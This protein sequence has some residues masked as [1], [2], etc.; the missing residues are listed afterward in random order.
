MRDGFQVWSGVCNRHQLLRFLVRL[1]GMSEDKARQLLDPADKQ[2]VP[3]AVALLQ[4]ICNLRHF[5]G[6]DLLNSCSPSNIFVRVTI[7]Y[8]D[9]YFFSQIKQM[10]LCLEQL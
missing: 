9:G 8:P 6:G 7:H 1:H 10:Y 4:A 5:T 3:K 2:N